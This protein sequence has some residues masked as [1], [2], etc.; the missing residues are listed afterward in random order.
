MPWNSVYP[1]TQVKRLKQDTDIDVYIKPTQLPKTKYFI[2]DGIK[3]PKYIPNP[4][5]YQIKSFIENL[6][7][8]EKI[9]ESVITA[10]V[11][12]NDEQNKLKVKDVK[13]NNKKEYMLND[14]YK[15]GTG[16]RAFLPLEITLT[17]V[18]NNTYEEFDLNIKMDGPYDPEWETETSSK[19]YKV[20]DMGNE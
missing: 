12:L 20:K 5:D 6:K 11:Y 17:L 4:K 10:S 18:N 19:K 3:E 1:T 16:E 13:I 9:K 8:A 15:T 14:V 2:L 7:H